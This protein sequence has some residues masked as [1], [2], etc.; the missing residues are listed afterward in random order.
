MDE[1]AKELIDTLARPDESAT[2][3][4]ADKFRGAEGQAR[5]NLLFERLAERAHVRAL[6][7]VEAGGSAERWAEAWELLV[8]L[9]REAEALNL[10][11]TDAFFTALSR[12]KAIA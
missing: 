2:L 11:R 1:A 9:P 4:L 5:F 8:R 12:L 3:A 10:D 7:D 6:R